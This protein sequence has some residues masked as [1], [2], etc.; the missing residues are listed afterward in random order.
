M[1]RRIGT[2]SPVQR[3]A[4]GFERIERRLS[5]ILARAIEADLRDAGYEVLGRTD[6]GAVVYLEPAEV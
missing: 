3:L 1:K 2:W 6:R 4:R 5:G